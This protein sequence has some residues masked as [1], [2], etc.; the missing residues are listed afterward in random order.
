MDHKRLLHAHKNGNCKKTRRQLY[1]RVL[2]SCD[3][4]RLFIERDDKKEHYEDETR[5]L[6]SKYGYGDRFSLFFELCDVKNM[7]DKCK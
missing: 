3:L 6:Y 4:P 7:K 2:H 5:E 1:H